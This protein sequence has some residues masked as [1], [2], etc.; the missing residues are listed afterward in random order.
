VITR[1]AFDMADHQRSF[2]A[3]QIHW[4]RM[5]D[6]RV[7]EH[8]ANRGD[9]TSMLQLGVVTKPRLV[10]ALREV[11]AATRRRFRRT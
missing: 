7:A 6:G 2:R 10:A 4:F 5:T 3:E 9:L 8:W 11:V 1:R